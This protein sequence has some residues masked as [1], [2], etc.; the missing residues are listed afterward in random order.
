M[1]VTNSV[2]GVHG[3]K[4][5]RLFEMVASFISHTSVFEMALTDLPMGKTISSL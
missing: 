2:G 3:A 1:S 5:R 4:H